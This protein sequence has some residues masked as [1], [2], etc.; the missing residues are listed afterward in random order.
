MSDDYTVEQFTEDF[1]W[2][3]GKKPLNLEKLQ[4]HLKRCAE[5]W[6]SL[7]PNP[8]TEEHPVVFL[9]LEEVAGNMLSLRHRGLPGWSSWV[10]EGIFFRVLRKLLSEAST[11]QLDAAVDL[12]LETGRFPYEYFGELLGSLGEIMPGILEETMSYVY[13][14]E[15]PKN[16][17]EPQPIEEPLE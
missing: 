7:N 4:E 14:M 1:N 8:D 12:Y 9:A 17:K 10:D 15:V 5:K 6:G 16:E 13:R 2:V 3:L 11:D